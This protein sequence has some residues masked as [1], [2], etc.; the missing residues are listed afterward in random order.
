MYAYY[1][2]SWGGQMGAV[3]IPIE[4]R[5]KVGLLY[6][7]GLMFQKALPEVDPVNYISRI[8]IPTIMM[9]GKYDHYFP[10]ETS[11]KPMFDFISTP[12]EHKKHYVFE[13]GHYVPRK[14]LAKELLGWLDKYLN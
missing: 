3:M 6:V 9:N 11:Q 8:T 2:L 13:T 7:A 12:V 1:G 14:E 10:L 4:N 5:F